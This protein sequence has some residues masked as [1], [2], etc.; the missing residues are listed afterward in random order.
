MDEHQP[1]ARTSCDNESL[2]LDPS[3]I[4]ASTMGL[5]TVEIDSLLA[6]LQPRKGSSSKASTSSS[7]ASASASGSRRR[8]HA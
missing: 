3:F 4:R 8:G 6:E 2:G 7:S 5:E 1:S